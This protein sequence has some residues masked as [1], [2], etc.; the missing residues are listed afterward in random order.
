[1]KKLHTS[2]FASSSSPPP[3]SPLIDSEPRQETKHQK[4]SANGTSLQMEGERRGFITEK[5]GEGRESRRRRNGWTLW[6]IVGGHLC[7]RTNNCRS[8]VDVDECWRRGL[9]RETLGIGAALQGRRPTWTVSCWGSWHK[10]ISILCQ[11]I[12]LHYWKNIMSC[13]ILF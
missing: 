9:V 2:Q 8:R 3:P 1:M 4:R 11:V 13:T 10:V 12:S 6:M 5:V 7:R